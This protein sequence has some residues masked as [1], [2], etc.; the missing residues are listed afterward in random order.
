MVPCDDRLMF[1]YRLA[2]SVP[3]N[4]MFVL[5]NASACLAGGERARMG[6]MSL[7]GPWEI[8]PLFAI[9]VTF[10]NSTVSVIPAKERT[11]VVLLSH[12]CVSQKGA[13]GTPL[14]K[15]SICFNLEGQKK[16]QIS[17][18]ALKISKAPPLNWNSLLAFIQTDLWSCTLQKNIYLCRSQWQFL[19][20]RGL[21]RSLSYSS[22]SD[23]PPCC[24]GSRHTR[25][26]SA[27]PS[28]ATTHDW[29]DSSRRD[30]YTCTLG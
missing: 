28:P 13:G 30:H 6:K 27:V 26:R 22:G 4:G 7:H 3:K 14:S 10:Q 17:I 24:G 2:S 21:W 8:P 25:H 16:N 29:S 15:R 12:H 20:G 19:V 9:T 1:C 5:K 18:T 11:R 23:G